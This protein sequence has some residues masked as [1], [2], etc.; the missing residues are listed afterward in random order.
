MASLPLDVPPLPASVPQTVRAI[1][2]QMADHTHLAPALLDDAVEL[3]AHHPQVA[4]S[5]LA[6]LEGRLGELDLDR[7]RAL[8]VVATDGAHSAW[9]DALWRALCARDEPAQIA[10][11]LVQGLDLPGASTQAYCGLHARLSARSTASAQQLSQAL[12]TNA[13]HH[14]FRGAW[15]GAGLLFE[16]IVAREN[17]RAFRVE[18]HHKHGHTWLGVLE[19]ALTE[20]LEQEYSHAWYA[21]MHWQMSQQMNRLLEAGV[22]PNGPDG[23]ACAQALGRGLGRCEPLFGGLLAQW[24]EAGGAWDVL[25]EHTGPGVR[26]WIDHQPRVRRQRLGALSQGAQDSETTHRAL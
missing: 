14:A 5:L 6:V 9:L 15:V 13:L 20:L 18:G 16:A 4:G 21:G 17:A 11:R 1:E 2:Q 3:L 22:E 7:L 12:A 10:C 19:Q 24:M 8:W 25:W 23:L 26:R